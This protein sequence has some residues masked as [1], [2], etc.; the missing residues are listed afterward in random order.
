MQSVIAQYGTPAYVGCFDT[1]SSEM[2]ERDTVI[3]VQSPRGIELA[4]VLGT[5][6]LSTAIDPLA[7]GTLLR[8][9][10]VDDL[11]K[12]RIHNERAEHLIESTAQFVEEHQLPLIPLEAEIMLEDENA[13]LHI[14]VL[15]E[16]DASA[17]IAELNQHF[18]L[19]ITLLE[20]GN[21]SAANAPA[22][23]CDK[24][25]CGTESGG[26]TTCSSGGCARKEV[27][28]ADDLTTYFAG[29]RQQMEQQSS[30]IPLHG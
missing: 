12:Q 11:Q 15:E 9:A 4:T 8:R 29:L 25:G 6:Q 13:I 24:P 20:S 1:T 16:C 7:G 14:L 3:V 10:D 17:M 2:Y 19:T 21:Y 27:K 30:R 5:S 22:P 26:C 18:T 28:S 23:T